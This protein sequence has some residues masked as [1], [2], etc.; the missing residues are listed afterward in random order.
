[1]LETADQLLCTGKIVSKILANHLNTLLPHLVANYHSGF[2]QGRNILGGVTQVIIHHS[3]KTNKR[4]YL[5]KLDF[6]KAYDLINWKCLVE[7]L[8]NRGFK[9]KLIWWVKLRL[10]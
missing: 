4:G 10:G 8:E 2:I 5:F 6:E 7:I 3:N 1:M 9:V